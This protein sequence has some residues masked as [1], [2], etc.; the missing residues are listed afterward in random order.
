MESR[1]IPY[2]RLVAD[3]ISNKDIQTKP[4]LVRGVDPATW[5]KVRSEA[6]RRGLRTGVAVSEALK[7]WL[8]KGRAS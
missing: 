3:N 7:L 5:R 2:A 4:V 6:I 8:G 1:N